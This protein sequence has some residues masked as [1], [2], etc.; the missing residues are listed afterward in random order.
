M[1]RALA[2]FCTVFMFAAYGSAVSG[3]DALRVA[4]SIA[5]QRY[6]V[7]RIGGDRVTVD[8]MVPAGA[9]PHSFEP[10][11]AQ[12][13]GLAN[14]DAYFAVGVT[15]ERAWL[16]RFRSVNQDMRLVH[17]DEGIEKIPISGHDHDHDHGEADEH[18]HD[19]DNNEDSHGE[20][21]PHIWLS[22]RLVRIQADTIYRALVDLD[23]SGAEIYRD[24]HRALVADIDHLHEELAGLFAPFRGMAFM[25]FHPAWGYFADAYGL[26][27][28]A[29]EGDGREPRPADLARLISFAR[30]HDIRAV[31]VQPQFSKRS[32]RTIADA[33]GGTVVE[34]DP[35][36]EDWFVNMRKVAGAFGEAMRRNR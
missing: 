6:F 29:V 32:A 12:I 20:P 23:P 33:V 8:V 30:E 9:E 10:K 34:A 7:E 4:V 11:P 24:N 28:V 21:D 19:D 27:Q 1:K 31:F 22:P 5:P 13:A 16:N 2:C 17:T 15:F 26:E 14:A 25:V 36:A 3:S 35:M 18:G